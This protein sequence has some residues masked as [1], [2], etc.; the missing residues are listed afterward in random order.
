[1][2]PTQFDKIGSLPGK[3]HLHLQDGVTPFID[4]PRK[5]SI[6]LKPKLKAELDKMEMQQV[7]IRVTEHSDWCSSLVTSIKK[8]GSLR[9]CLDPRKLN[10]ALKRCPHKTLTIEEISHQFHGAK[11]FSKLDAQSGYWSVELDED[12]QALTT[13][14]TP[15]GRYK[16]KRLPFGLN[17]S[18]DLFQQKVDEILENCPGTVGI[19]DDIACYGS[20]EA[21]HD[22]NLLNL[23]REAQKHGLVFN[24]SKCTIKQHEIEYFGMVISVNGMK[25]DEAKVEDLQSM[26]APQNKTELQEFLGMI[27]FLSPFIRNLSAHAEPIRKLLCKDTPYEWSE[28]HQHVFDHLKTIISTEACL[29]FYDTNAPTYLMVD[30]SQRGLGA[31]LLQPDKQQD[32]DYSRELRP[33]VF[34][35]K[36]LSKSQKNYV[37]IEREMLA[38]TYGIKRLHTYLYGRPFTVLSDHKPLEIICNKPLTNAPAR[39]QAMMLAIQGYDYK[40]KHIP[41]K[42]IGLAD[43][44]SRL[45]NPNNTD[46]VDV[47]VRVELVQFSTNMVKEIQEA[48]GKE[49]TLN[50]LK[51]TIYNGWPDTQ[52][53]IATHLREFWAYR[54]ELSVYNGIIHKGER[55]FIPR[56]LRPKILANLHTGHLGITKT[57]LR[58]KKDVFWPNI[59][60]DIER[61]C[62]DC[63]VCREH[64]P[65]QQHQPL[66]QTEVP[67][68]PWCTIGTDLFQLGEDQY[69][70]LVDYYSKFPLVDKLPKPATS[71]TVAS[72]TAKH[73]AIFGIPNIIRSDNGPHYVGQAY[74][75]FT[76]KWGITHITSSPRYPRSNGFVERQIQ[77]VKAIL[78]K[79]KQAQEDVN[80]AL[81]RWRTTPVDHIIQSPAEIIFQRRIR[82]TL[83]SKI[84]NTIPNREEVHGQLGSKQAEQKSHH[85]AKARSLP[86]LYTGQYVTHRDPQTGR[87]HPAVVKDKTSEPR[88]YLIQTPHGQHL[89]RNRE[90]LREGPRDHTPT[91]VVTP[92]TPSNVAKSPQTPSVT[93]ATN[94]ANPDTGSG[95]STASPTRSAQAAG[96]TTPSLSTTR[97]GRSITKPARF[98]D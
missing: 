28:D 79:A 85:D 63:D 83:P 90:H 65:S 56:P 64:Q 77:T 87:W 44:L 95:I 88:S 93:Q 59:N 5:Y 46:D 61:M 80:L 60:K 23:M 39:L 17:V 45:P 96:A 27:T 54:E 33:V 75:D 30:A 40:V 62:K 22:A 50:E 16:F 52:S 86:P 42:D 37:S 71:E 49:P 82:D 4:P 73:C 36:S 13:F 84:T 25:P 70:I 58:A 20:S 69:L 55:V 34:A 92:N 8:D 38:I 18:Q 78:K 21:E 66:L 76:N 41:G 29:K 31:A 43:A 97:Y 15:F 10:E 51:E 11:Y 1:M 35:S 26:P 91:L 67:S 6:H 19:A 98:R 47:D 9:V 53:E 24:S 74:K 12:S 81:L 32:G 89:R 57:Q 3:V 72:I 68:K 7:I 48:T 14:R 2:F 94:T